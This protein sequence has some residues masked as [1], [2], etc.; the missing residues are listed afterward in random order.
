MDHEP[1]GARAPAAEDQSVDA[2]EL[3]RPEMLHRVMDREHR[4][5]A[6]SEREEAG[7]VVLVYVDDVRLPLPQ[8]APDPS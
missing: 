5:V 8:L 1:F 2:A 3:P 6:G 7:I 4:S